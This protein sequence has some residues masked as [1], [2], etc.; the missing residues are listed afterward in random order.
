[1]SDKPI[2]YIAYNWVGPVGP[3]GNIR[4]PDIYDL[5]LSENYDFLEQHY[6]SGAAKETFGPNCADYGPKTGANFQITA[7]AGLKPEDTFLYPI[8]LGHKDPMQML[9]DGVFGIFE[10]SRIPRRTLELI[11]HCKGYIVLEHGFEAFVTDP[12]IDVI[13]NYMDMHQIPM[14]KVIYATGTG[15]IKEVYDNYCQRKQIPDSERIRFVRFYPTMESFAYNETNDPHEVEYDP[16]YMPSKTFLSLNL[17]PRQHRT[18]L[19]GMFEKHGLIDQSYFSY[20]GL[21]HGERLTGM[22][23][24][25]HL[26]ALD[27]DQSIYERLEARMSDFVLDHDQPES[28]VDVV[29]DIGNHDTVAPFYHDSLVSVATETTFHTHIMAVTE[30]SFKGIKYKSPFILLGAQG[31]LQNIKDLGYQTFEE[32]WDEGYDDIH[33]PNKRLQRVVQICKEIDGWSEAE[34]REFRHKVKPI[35]EHNY[36]RLIENPFSDVYKDMYQY[37]LA[38]R[39]KL[40]ITEDIR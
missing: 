14:N 7:A 38:D 21:R 10:R 2:I 36:Q 25:N 16:E 26:Q 19:I 33:N 5:A 31:L 23:D 37:V 34:R 4:T 3:I 35:L 22:L 8:T 12:E 9:F 29:Y 6:A 28:I 30:K 1:M 24:Q 18:L 11:R 20:A 15:N 32:F 40:V 27:L 17:R 39:E 13:H